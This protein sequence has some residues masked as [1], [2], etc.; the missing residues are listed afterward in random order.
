MKTVPVFFICDDNY[1]KILHVALSSVKAFASPKNNYNIH[2]LTS[3]LS[4]K[5]ADSFSIFNAKN[6]NIFVEDVTDAIGGREKIL[7]SDFFPI[8]TYFRMFI[9]NHFPQYDK[10]ICLDVDLVLNAD[11][12]ELYA[13]NLGGDWI[14]GVAKN[15]GKDNK[16][17]EYEKSAEKKIDDPPPP[18][19]YHYAEKFIGVPLGDYFNNGV[20]LMNCKKLREIDLE[21]QCWNILQKAPQIKKF[22]CEQGCFN[23]ICKGKVVFLPKTWNYVARNER[24]PIEEIKLIHYSLNLKPWICSNIAYQDKFWEHAKNTIFYNDLLRTIDENNK[25]NASATL[26]ERTKVVFNM[27]AD[28]DFNTSLEKLL[29]TLGE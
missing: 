22:D 21:G 19:V 10:A 26:D 18:N 9:P 20:L 16:T 25:K 8:T 5:N 2:I 17:N 14:G 29:L 23:Y 1:V 4:K 7:K 11:I 28:P 13:V 24:L 27:P 15:R 6:F 12:A 3:G